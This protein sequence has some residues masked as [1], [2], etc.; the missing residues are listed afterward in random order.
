MVYGI[1]IDSSSSYG[2]GAILACEG[3][4]PTHLPRLP[5]SRQHAFIFCETDRVG[6]PQPTS[7]PRTSLSVPMGGEGQLTGDTVGG[8]L[9]DLGGSFPQEACPA[10]PAGCGF[11]SLVFTCICRFFFRLSQPSPNFAR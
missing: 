11:C 7:L 1:L 2:P 5:R 3:Q 9:P 6:P 8:I 10:A 4:S